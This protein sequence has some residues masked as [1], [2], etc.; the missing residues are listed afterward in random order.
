MYDVNVILKDEIRRCHQRD[1]HFKK[2]LQ[3]YYDTFED[4]DHSIYKIK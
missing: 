2:V 1:A 4:A 3:S